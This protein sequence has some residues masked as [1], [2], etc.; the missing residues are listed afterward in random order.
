MMTVIMIVIKAELVDPSALH[1]VLEGD[2][3]SSFEIWVILNVLREDEVI[4]WLI[5]LVSLEKACKDDIG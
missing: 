1:R 4:R 5:H 2:N 3:S